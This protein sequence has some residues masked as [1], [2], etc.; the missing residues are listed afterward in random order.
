MDMGL[1]ETFFTRRSV[2]KYTSTPLSTEVLSEV[3]SVLDGAE[4]ISG[5]TASFEILEA[6]KVKDAATPHA[7]Y[8]IIARSEQTDTAYANVGFVL[9]KVD[10]FLQSKGLGSCWLGMAKPTD[11]PDDYTVMMAFGYTEIPVRGSESEF[12]RIALDDISN[13]DNAVAR[14][15]R[16]A[17][18]AVNSQP[19]KLSFEPGKVVIGYFGRGLLKLILRKKMAK[20]DVG[21]ISRFVTL[22]LENEG[23]TVTEVNTDADGKDLR[24]TVL[25]N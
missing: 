14:A 20:I 5:Q 16:L 12:N 22:A 1:Y 3:R 13:E 21:I 11:V 15:A 23:K 7:P 25:Y 9:E 8:Y 2:R 24:V 19:W 17:P 4:Q 18:S 10:L 6:V